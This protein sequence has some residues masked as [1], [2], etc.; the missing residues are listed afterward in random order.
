MNT[1]KDFQKE[2]LS[3]SKYMVAHTSGSTGTPK[4]IHLQKD[5]MIASAK[6]TNEFFNIRSGDNLV[7]PLSL[8][9]IAAKMMAVRAIIADAN[10]I[11]QKPSND[12]CVNEPAKLLAIVPSQ[13]DSLLAQPTLTDT[14]ENIIIGGAPLSMEKR[15]ALISVGFNAY[16]TYGMTETCSHVALKHIKDDCFTAIGN[17]TFE[18]DNRGCLV[19]NIP[20]LLTNR[21]VTNDVVT[22]HDERTF[23]WLGRIDNVINSG[24]IKIHPEL[25]EKKISEIIG[26][27]YPFYIAGMP[28]DKWGQ[29]VVL[30]IEAEQEVADDFLRKISESM[31]HKFIP[32]K[33]IAV[34][35]IQRT[36]NGKIIR[37]I[38]GL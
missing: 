3:D 32:K 4:E 19:I 7:C 31:D 37:Q 27:R 13:V 25:L 8:N 10:L 16:E 1:Y 28:S 21:V 9:Y 35:K 2:W 17:T 36:P 18:L 24:G 38:V 15:E 12:L 34:R 30:V 20:H 11:L 5:D 23:S 29:E 33:I 22:L 14:I 6:A 26:D